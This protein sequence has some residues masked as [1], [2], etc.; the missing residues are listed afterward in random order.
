M[1]EFLKATIPYFLGLGCLILFFR[2]SVIVD[3]VKHSFIK[4]L[5]GVILLLIALIA[6]MF[7]IH[8]DIYSSYDKL[9][10]QLHS[11]FNWFDPIDIIKFPTEQYGINHG[12]FPDYTVNVNCNDRINPQT[13]KYTFVI[14]KSLSTEK[15]D[16][17]KSLVKSYVDVLSKNLG[18]ECSKR[19]VDFSNLELE[20]LLLCMAL[21]SISNDVYKDSV[22]VDL[23][24]YLGN[25]N[26]YTPC[27]IDNI[28]I[29]QKNSCSTILNLIDTIQTVVYP[30]V[31]KIPPTHKTD[32]AYV[33]SVLNQHSWL[34]RDK[35]YYNSVFFISDFEHEE[36]SGS[37]F[38]TLDY[39][40]KNLGSTCGLEHFSLIKMQGKNNNGAVVN[41]T[42]ELF[43]KNFGHLYYYEIDES[44]NEN[45]NIIAQAKNIFAIVK[46]DNQ[47]IV[48]Y[49][50]WDSI[51]YQF[52]YR[53]DFFTDNKENEIF[54]F[55]FGNRSH[56]E[57]FKDKSSYGLE[58]NSSKKLF[59]YEMVSQ[60]LNYNQKVKLLFSTNRDE[61]RDFFIEVRDPNSMVK[62]R[63]PMVLRETL[64]V[65]SCICLIYLYS[66]FLISVLAYLLF[67][68]LKLV[69]SP[70]ANQKQILKIVGLTLITLFLIAWIIYSF[71]FG[72]SFIPILLTLIKLFSSFNITVYF[73]LCFVYSIF[74][75]LY[76]IMNWNESR[77]TYSFVQ[78]ETGVA[79]RNK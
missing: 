78:D 63:K 8:A 7:G 68:S 6:F 19:K 54:Y 29:N 33:A 18:E 76:A 1:P 72:I 64:P 21:Y 43:R 44:F 38:Y 3:I 42:L 41:E 62:L 28:E 34:Q 60:Q 57:I 36:L 49:T 45:D 31:K 39:K 67:I 13:T 30:K 79:K 59:P 73:I 51:S 20:D 58:I 22:Q 10:T 27:R 50:T 14:D 23:M 25:Q 11:S 70:I 5:S 15:S 37:S 77:V 35:N 71:A 55:G 2:L 26:Y 74:L 65:T 24:Y 56:Q 66:F 75:F 32:L 16:L 9:N 52:D 48:F 12:K 17:T 53:S 46:E 69:V 4:F 47:P 61:C 40:L